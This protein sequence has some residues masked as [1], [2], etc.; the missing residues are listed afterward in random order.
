MSVNEHDRQDQKYEQ[1]RFRD[2]MRRHYN[3]EQNA[4]N[5]FIN[6]SPQL[7]DTFELFTN[8]LQTLKNTFYQ[9]KNNLTNQKPASSSKVKIE[10]EIS[11]L[12]DEYQDNPMEFLEDIE[13][14]FY[15]KKHSHKL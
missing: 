5:N 6:Q 4:P 1:D 3:A 2:E 12:H 7:G 13:R 8:L 9:L 15:I 14:Y 11:K 10:L